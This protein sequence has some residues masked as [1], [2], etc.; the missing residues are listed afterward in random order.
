[1][2][3]KSPPPFLAT[4]TQPTPPAAPH[5]SRKAMLTG[6]RMTPPGR[7]EMLL[8]A[9][10]PCPTTPAPHSLGPYQGLGVGCW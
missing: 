8:C 3:Q 6:G 1:M 10:L 2:T 9:P 5:S 4:L 7:A